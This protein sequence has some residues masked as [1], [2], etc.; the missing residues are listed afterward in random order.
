MEIPETGNVKNKIDPLFD[1]HIEK[2][3][4]RM[5]PREKLHYLWL[6]TEFRY[7]IKNRKIISKKDTANE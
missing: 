2:P 5:T 3:L 1:G 6:Q 7:I 4:S